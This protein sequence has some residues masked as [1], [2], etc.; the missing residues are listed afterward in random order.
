MLTP[1][2]YPLV[3]T[4]QPMS[5]HRLQL[6]FENGEVRIFDAN[7]MLEGTAGKWL[8]ELLNDDYFNQAFVSDGIVNWPNEQDICPDCIYEDSVP[9]K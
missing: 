9:I 4:V 8:G 2:G 3:Q 7:P 5:D 1:Y 6:T